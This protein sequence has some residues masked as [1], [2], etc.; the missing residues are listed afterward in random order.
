MKKVWQNDRQ[1]DGRTDRKDCSKSCLVA[2]KIRY[3]MF[4]LYATYFL[5]VHPSICKAFYPSITQVSICSWG[6]RTIPLECLKENRFKHCFLCK[7]TLKKGGL[8]CFLVVICRT[9]GQNG[10]KIGMMGKFSFV[11]LF[12]LF[13]CKSIFMMTTRVSTITLRKYILFPQTKPY[14]LLGPYASYKY[15]TGGSV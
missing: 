4:A 1:A 11:T 8:G 14:V 10:L 13:S 3:T 7:S 5:M 12:R 2:A 15:I 6:L 9:Y